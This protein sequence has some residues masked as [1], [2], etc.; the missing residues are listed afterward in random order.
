MTFL[1]KAR[2]LRAFLLFCAILPLSNL[3]GQTT[4]V[5]YSLLFCSGSTADLATA[6]PT[7]RQYTCVP[8]ASTAVQGA[9]S[10][11]NSATLNQ[12]LNLANTGT[13]S[14]NIIFDVTDVQT[15]GGSY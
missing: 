14:A 2:L 1:F 8:R 6:L 4:N 13:A 15:P 3:F 9:V 12:T 11:T 7:G 10:I 5:T